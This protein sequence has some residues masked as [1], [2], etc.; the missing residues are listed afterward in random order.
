MYHVGERRGMV[1][2]TLTSRRAV[3]GAIP[4]RIIV[5]RFHVPPEDEMN[6]PGAMRDVL[7]GKTRR[8]PGNLADQPCS[9][10]RPW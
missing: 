7:P 6:D 10:N 4:F 3:F 9:G 1:G 5:R 2:G 8:R